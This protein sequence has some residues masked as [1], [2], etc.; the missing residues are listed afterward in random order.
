MGKRIRLFTSGT[1]KGLHFSDEDVKSIAEKTAAQGPELI[2]VVLGHPANDLPVLGKVSK[3]ALQMYQENG[4]IA[5]GFDRDDAQ[6][7]EDEV[8]A[9][10][11]KLR[12]KISVR[13]KDS[14]IRH[15]GLVGKAAVAENNE[16]DF[17]TLTGD[18][19]APDLITEQPTS[20]AERVGQFFNKQKNM[21][22][23]KEKQNQDFTALGGKVDTLVATVNTLVG[24]LNA[25]NKKEDEKGL[26]TTISADFSAQEFSHLNDVQKQGCIDFC[27]SL[28]A[29]QRDAY[30]KQIASLNIK[31]ATPVKGSV[32]VD[33][34]A[35][36]DSK[37]SSLEIITEQIAALK[38]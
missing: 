36:K 14:V 38:S 13:L 21:E 4:K 15:I 37:K 27:A 17:A 35:N 19:D 10:N 5:I 23:D 8:F 22:Q 30:K 16:Q 29:D 33:L 12:N 2:P 11:T 1:H 3:D 7:C 6:L 32:T 31:P 34:G 20:F 26:K 24:V 25:N 9:E 28:S 18:F